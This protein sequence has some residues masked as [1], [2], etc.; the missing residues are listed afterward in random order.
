MTD[1][2][3]TKTLTGTVVSAK[4]KDT[5]TVAVNR[6]VKHPKYGKFMKKTKKYLVHDE[7]NT[8]KEGDK[9]TIVSCRPMSKMKKFTLVSD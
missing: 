1:T 8:A 2:K 9:V 3:K 4:A 7:G 5:V 6:Y